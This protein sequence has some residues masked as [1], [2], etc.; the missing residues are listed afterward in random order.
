MNYY[1]E[2]KNKIIDDIAYQKVKDYSKEQHKVKIYFEIGKLL[3]DAGKHYG[4]NII[5][6]YAKKLVKEVGKKYNE[7]TLRSTRQ[8]Y[9][10]FSS[11]IWKPLV[12]KLT[13][14]HFLIL[15]PIKNN[16][17]MYYYANQVIE[18]HLS[19]RQLQEII[20][21]KEY[22]RLPDKTKEKLIN[23]ENNEIQDFIKHPIIINNSKNIIDISEKV[24]K[25]LI[26]D[27]LSNFLKQL[28]DGFC[29]VENEYKII[30]GNTPNFIDILLFNYIYNCFVVV[31]LKV[32]PVNKNHIGQIQ[33]YM[34]YL[35]KNIK[36][37]YQD[38]T[39][40]IIIAK[41]ENHFIIEYS[42]DNRIF[43]TTYFLKN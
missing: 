39:I 32:V 15:M 42:S 5:D 37:I 35:D 21:S 29:Y 6:E 19:K 13:W 18:R 38:N 3:N 16:N 31:E 36:T 24:L 26:L 41:E 33:V 27:D 4:E 8:L 20:K 34:N 28:G 2:I 10:M 7:R 11:E 30:I 23:N 17:I 43:E 9:N 22:E 12:S 40:G 25:E 14:T 1:N